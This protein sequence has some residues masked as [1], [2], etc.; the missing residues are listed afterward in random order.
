MKTPISPEGHEGA[1]L[2][3]WVKKKRW[4]DRVFAQKLG[5]SQPSVRYWY[6]S[7]HIPPKSRQKLADIGFPIEVGEPY[8]GSGDGLLLREYMQQHN[9]KS[10]DLAKRMEVSQQS[11][12]N[13]YHYPKFSKRFKSDIAA[14]GIEI[15]KDAL[16]KGN[17]SSQQTLLDP[18]AEY[19]TGSRKRVRIVHAQAYAGYLQGYNDMNYLNSLPEHEIVVDED[20]DF[21]T[22][23][24]KGDSM[25]PDFPDGCYVDCKEL[26]P[27]LWRN[28]IRGRVFMFL[29]PDYGLQIK[30]L[31]KQDGQT[32]TF[33]PINQMYKD[34]DVDLSQVTKLWYFHQ[35]HDTTRDYSRYLVR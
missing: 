3:A 28:L 8:T 22:F 14:A 35:K 13:A 10:S 34:F 24:V 1:A 17:K 5:V 15:F 27:S 20:G 19:A 32:A 26:E 16:A 21:I 11:I 23:E 12:T 18:S 6:R 4:S 25:E 33:R 7:E 31:L 29:H 9:I 2:K 30:V